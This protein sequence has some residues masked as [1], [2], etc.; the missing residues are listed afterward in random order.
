MKKILKKL[1][2]YY[3]IF[4]VVKGILSYLIPAPSAFSDSYIYMKLARSFFFDSNFVINNIPVTHYLPLYPIILSFSYLF[5]QMS[6]I[7]PVMKIINVIISSLVIFPA[8]FISKEFFNSNKSLKIAI[9][10][11]LLPSNFIFSGYILAENIFYPLFLFSIYFIY[12]SITVKRIIWPILAGI[13]IGLTYLSKI[14]GIVLFP[15]LTILFLFKLINEEKIFLRNILLIGFTALLIISPWLWNNYLI[16]GNILGGYSEEA[17]TIFSLNE[18]LLKYL[19][20]FILYIG[21]LVISAGI[22]LPIKIS[23]KIFSKLDFAILSLSSI[24]F[25]LI[26][27]SNHNITAT[28]TSL[29]DLPA[30]Y[31]PWLAGRLIG[32]YIDVVLPL[33]IILGLF[34]LEDKINLKK[35]IAYSL[36]LIF[37]SQLLLTTLFPSNHV[38]TAYLG[39]FNHLLLLI[40]SFPINLIIIGIILGIIPFI[41]YKLNFKK[42]INLFIIFFI[43]LNILNFT[44]IYYDSNIYWYKGDQMQ[45]GLWLD[46]HDPEISTILFDKR[47]CSDRILKLNQSSICEP[48]GFTTI[49]G[50]WLNDEIIVDYPTS[51]EGID[52]IISRHNFDLP[53]VYSK[54]NLYIYSTN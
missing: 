17:S 53:I 34:C 33:V 48:S 7:Y 43:L 22:F 14:N 15:V 29:P 6:I 3:F 44:L 25:T 39:L 9:L 27:A 41:F 28:A 10:I 51:L 11:S 20:Q 1:A 38:S 21:L 49:I 31:F 42:T 5:N 37:S 46:S 12:K 18:F 52:F 50:V 40:T 16:Q 4:I 19:V 13:S 45:L 32:R 30:K 26:M 47:D 36:L 54:D 35:K 24:F 2:L 23:K 8:Y